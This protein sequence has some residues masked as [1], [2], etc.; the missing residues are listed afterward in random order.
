MN[1]LPLISVICPTHYGRERHLE[2]AIKYFLAQDFERKELIVVSDEKGT[3]VDTE[4][5][6]NRFLTVKCGYQPQKT[7]GEKRNV[8]CANAY[9]DVICMCDDDDYFAPEWLTR[10]Y[11]HLAATQADL[12]G[13][14]HAYFYKPHSQMWEYKYTGSQPYVLEG[15]MMFR[16]DVWK[17][18]PFKHTSAGEGRDF[19]ANAGIVKPHNYTD[20]F[21][22]I[23]HGANTESQNSLKVMKP[24]N[25]DLAKT[26]LGSNF[27]KYP[28]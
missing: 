17:R 8:G 1:N 12:T 21:L 28:L 26:I 2:Q 13:L 11:N 27:K 10:S 25:P 6:G 7:I 22:A 3:S 20:G 14:S 16:K 15:T 18:R 23:I 9:G 19:V 24:I 5:Q 4:L